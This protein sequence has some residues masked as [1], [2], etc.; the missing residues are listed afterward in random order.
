MGVVSKYDVMSEYNS[1]VQGSGQADQP[2]LLH[3]P[4]LMYKGHLQQ[5]IK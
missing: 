5:A 4:V 1:L 2:L 3:S